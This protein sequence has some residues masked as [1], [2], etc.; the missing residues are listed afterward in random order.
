MVVGSCVDDSRMVIFL[1]QAKVREAL[2]VGDIKFESCNDDLHFAMKD[3][4]MVNLETKIPD[5]VQRWNQTSGL[6]RR[7][8]CN[9]QLAR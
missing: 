4:V 2:G 3:D 7:V 6:C 1:N 9:L 5:L 8:R